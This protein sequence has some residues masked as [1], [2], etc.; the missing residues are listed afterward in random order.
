[1]T[2][3]TG[4]TRDRI[5]AA[6][7][8]MALTHRERLPIIKGMFVAL[9]AR[10][11]LL[12]LGPGGTGKSFLVRDL[13]SRIVDSRYFEIAFDETSDPGQAFGPTD[14]K[15]MKDRFRVKGIFH[16]T[17]GDAFQHAK[18][19]ASGDIEVAQT[20]IEQVPGKYRRITTNMLPEA[21]IAFL[22]E[23]FN[24]NGPLL[25]GLMPI[26]NER[27][28]HNNGTPTA[29]PLWS[30]F[31]GTNKLNADADQAALWDRIHHRH[32]IAPVRGRDNLRQVALDSVTRRV[33]GFVEADKA[34]IELS[35]LHAAH[36]EAMR[37]EMPDNVLDTF[38]D[39]KEELFESGIDVSVRRMN[40]GYAAVLANSWLN[41]HDAVTTA[42]LD[43]LQSMW[44]V[45]QAD[46]DTAR[47]IILGAT[48]PGAKAALELL[49]QLDR[50]RAEL[51]VA[52]NDGRDPK[53]LRQ[54][55]MEAYKNYKRLAQ[56]AEELRVKAVAA[57]NATDRI[58]EAIG[59]ATQL[60]AKVEQ[61][62]FNIR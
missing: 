47:G 46:A 26:L 54:A 59:T 16:D 23:F 18:I 20:Y 56:E 45:L 42:D 57:G 40:E 53:H 38:M 1:M 17:W 4:T 28:F 21:E 49:D 55:G 11:H 50:V 13:A 15:S 19:L 8:E 31:A 9:L 34:T 7:T 62:V 32:V 41:G 43:V 52:Q 30:M 29:T 36:D 27:L 22:D 35:E 61:E 25:H 44:W 24:A 12:M 3:T 33:S 5:E 10:Q 39:I 51:A 48:N 37:L 14:I 6:I 58:D 2:T 60:T